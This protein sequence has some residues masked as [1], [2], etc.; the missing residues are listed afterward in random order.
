MPRSL[1]VL[2]CL[3]M[4]VGSAAAQE[5]RAEH[6]DLAYGDHARQKLDLTVPVSDKPLPLLIWVHGGGWEHGD[7]AGRNPAI[8]FLDKGYAVASVNYRYSTQAVFP[9]QYHDCQAA[10]RYLRRNAKKYNLDT[11][12]FGAWGASAGGHLVALL[13]TA[14]DVPELDG[15]PKAKVSSKV[16]A[17]F[18]WFGPTDLVKMTPAQV[19]D[20]PVARLLGGPAAEKKELATKANPIAHVSKGDAPFLIAHGTTDRLV[21]L[22]QSE[23]LQAALKKAGVESELLVFDGAGH[24]DPEFIKQAMAPANRE[25]VTAFFAKHLKHAS[26]K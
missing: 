26:A 5:A 6:K 18:D 21:P 25:K 17:V 16:Q 11:D 20:H 22:S 24:G 8:L 1:I 4:L 13:G 14:T 10:V 23:L 3:V 15:D 2:T 12:A 7:K 19:T 9:A